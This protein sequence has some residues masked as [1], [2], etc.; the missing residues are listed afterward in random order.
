MGRAYSFGLE[1]FAE[2]QFKK[3]DSTTTFFT[4]FGNFSAVYARYGQYEESALSENWVELVPPL[5]GKVGIKFNH[6][7]WEESILGTYVHRHFS[8]GTNAPNDPNAIAGII[9]SYF[10]ADFSAGYRFSK[11]FQIKAGINNLTNQMY[12]TRRATAYPGPGI[13]PADGINFYL[14]LNISL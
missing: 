12:F 4:V 6:G 7:N 14:T 1:L 8:D 11:L 2:H 9:P 5:S 13:I 3:N 10:V